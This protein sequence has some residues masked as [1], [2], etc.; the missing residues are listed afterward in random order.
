MDS[1][2]HWM[3][4]LALAMA[5][6]L[7]AMLLLPMFGEGVLGGTLVRNTLALLA[8]LPTLPLLGQLDWPM[9]QQDTGGF[10]LLLAG[11]VVIGLMLGFSAALPFWA[12]DMAGFLLDT[13]RGASM[14]G[15][16]NPLAGG[17]SS[18]LGA[19]FSQLAVVLFMVLGGFHALLTA[20][21]QSYQQLPPGAAWHW[22]GQALPFLMREWQ[23][24]YTLTLG[25][26]MPALVV[27]VLIDFGLGLINRTVQQLNVFS[28]SMPI[29]SAAALLMLIIG[30]QFG[31]SEILERFTAFD[32]GLVHML[33][34]AR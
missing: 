8:A 13:M 14:A 24:L 16:F 15:V 6:P 23:T 10:A 19:L 28:L 1:L 29:K 27:F 30:L 31:L 5:R 11:E 21:F 3:P 25:F 22:S 17:E 4:L 32:G 9:P 7:G 33:E 26:S 18:P 34:P 2:S 20:L 12:L